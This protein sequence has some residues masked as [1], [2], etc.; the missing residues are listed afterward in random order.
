MT[1]LKTFK[2]KNDPQSIRNAIAQCVAALTDLG[3]SSKVTRNQK[4]VRVISE[5]PVKNSE[6]GALSLVSFKLQLI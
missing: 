5:Q 3:C 4:T 2:I 6:T 1:T